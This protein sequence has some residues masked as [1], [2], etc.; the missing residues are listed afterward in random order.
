[1]QP[2]RLEKT[3]LF[4]IYMTNRVAL[5]LAN[6]HFQGEQF[7]FNYFIKHTSSPN[8]ISSFARGASEAMRTPSVDL[9]VP[10]AHLPLLAHLKYPKCFL[11]C[12]NAFVSFLKGRV[13]YFSENKA[14]GKTSSKV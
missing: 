12:V 4:I 13:A 1:M 8:I 5:T 3:H 7:I 14:K 2:N 9:Y 11:K 6:L 10:S